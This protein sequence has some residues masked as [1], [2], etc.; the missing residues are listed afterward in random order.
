MRFLR[1]PIPAAKRA[2]VR[3]GIPDKRLGRFLGPSPATR[4]IEATIYVRHSS[5]LER[6]EVFA[7]RNGLRVKEIDLLRG[8]MVVAGTIREFADT[9]QTGFVRM[10]FGREICRGLTRSAT[11]PG[12]IADRI[13]YVQ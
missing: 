3:G 8:Y 4:R 13:L 2:L 11:L 9:F 5:D 12:S 6:V 7:R 10:Q 1:K